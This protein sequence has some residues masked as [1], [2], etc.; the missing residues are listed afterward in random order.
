MK[1]TIVYAAVLFFFTVLNSC[2]TCSNEKERGRVKTGDK[3][4]MNTDS[5]E[6]K[7]LQFNIWGEGTAV[8]G[9]FDA[10]VDEVIN[11]EADLIALS[12]V[13]NYNDQG[14]AER[15]VNAMAEKGYTY[16]SERSEGSG[17]L[18]RFPIL[19]QEALYPLKNDQG[20]ITKA[21]IDAPSGL[22][23]FYS[24]HL[25]YTHYACYLPRGYDGITWKRLSAPIL[26]VNTILEQNKQSKRDEAIDVF[27]DDALEEHKKG[28]TVLLAGDFNEPSHLDWGE[29]SKEFF[30][31]NGMVVPWQNSIKLMENGFMD[32][33]RT[34]YLDPVTH[35]GLT[36]A[37]NNT[38]V[39]LDKL[40]WTSEADD[41]DRIDFIHYFP[42]KQLKLKD[43]VIV[44]PV[45]SIVKGKRVETNP[46]QDKFLL[47][48]GIWPSDHKAVL[49]TF[50]FHRLRK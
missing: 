4:E 23:S 48:K 16:Y 46:G 20:S 50:E 7:V 44:G 33:Y 5:V 34:K 39:K 28:N 22:I 25:D 21:M 9:G 35:P 41:R 40:V 27:I 30:D 18:S 2:N 8:P 36:W 13:R 47:P 1:H 49:A 29:A 15:L 24:A 11:T 43:V 37:A 26:D 45:G 32:A 6:L 31:H 38:G 17:I 10:M 14:L 3:I 19:S 12:E 42:N